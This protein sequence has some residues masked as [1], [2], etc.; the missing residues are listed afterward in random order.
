M[1]DLMAAFY[2]NY[3]EISNSSNRR[4]TPFVDLLCRPLL[5][6]LERFFDMPHIVEQSFA[7][8]GFGIDDVASADNG[9]RDLPAVAQVLQRAG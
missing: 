6:A 7:D 5:F 2:L 9:E 3:S 4:T 8:A 1:F